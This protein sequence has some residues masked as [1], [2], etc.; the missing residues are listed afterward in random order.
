VVIAIITVMMGIGVGVWVAFRSGSARDNAFRNLVL[1]CRRSRVFSLE[2]CQPSTLVLLR[3]GGGP[4][5]FYAEGLRLVGFWHLESSRPEQPEGHDPLKGFAGRE[6][7]QVGGEFFD[8]GGLIPGYHGSGIVFKHGGTIILPI[9]GLRLPRGGKISYHYMPL[10]TDR[11]QGLISRG[12]DL[13]VTLSP[14]GR[15]D[16]TVGRTM[17]STVRYRLPPGRWSHISLFYSGR[18]VSIA[19]NGV[20]RTRNG[21]EDEVELPDP[22]ELDLPLEIGAG[23]WKIFGYVDNIAVHRIVRESEILLPAEMR[24]ECDADRI[25]FDSAGMLDRRFHNG[26]VRIALVYP[27]EGGETGRRTVS[28]DL[29]GNVREEE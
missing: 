20:E 13:E 19:I 6:L 12:R 26:P 17:L 1:A 5:G 8:K 4:H 25:R 11:K 27:K 10:G 2:E 16:A 29:M 14:E 28:V 7:E 21:P 9:G 15:I 24:L 23:E 18:E 22:R 3:P